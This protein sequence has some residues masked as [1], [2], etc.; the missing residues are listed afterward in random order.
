VSRVVELAGTRTA[1]TW[2]SAAHTAP[3]AIAGAT[4]QSWKRQRHR[5]LLN[6]SAPHR[7]AQ[8]SDETAV[9]ASIAVELVIDRY[10][11]FVHWDSKTAR[12]GH[13]VPHEASSLGGSF[14]RPPVRVNVQ[15]EGA[16]ALA[17]RDQT[18]GLECLIGL[19]DSRRIDAEL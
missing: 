9:G 14:S 10:A 4:I 12:L 18:L 11:E 2:K 13:H 8:K 7:Q 6:A 3:A 15:D 16:G 17:S 19:D 1:R 5:E